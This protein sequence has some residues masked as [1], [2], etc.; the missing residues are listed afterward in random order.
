MFH[1]AGGKHKKLFGLRKKKSAGKTTSN[2]A[3]DFPGSRSSTLTS[4]RN[5]LLVGEDNMDTLSTHSTSTTST[6]A[7]MAQLSTSNPNLV[8]PDNISV[9]S[10][11][12]ATAVPTG[13]GGRP[14]SLP[15]DG[16]VAGFVL[17]PGQKTQAGTK[18]TYLFITGTSNMGG[19]TCEIWRSVA[20]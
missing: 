12:S 7:N 17:K 5:S 1:L 19:Y 9:Q 14:I 20:Q 11:T 18:M 4:E 2:N 8:Q 16:T 6:L 15:S 10:M 3:N 13:P